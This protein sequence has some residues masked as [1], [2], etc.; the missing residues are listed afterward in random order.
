MEGL[1]GHELNLLDKGLVSYLYISV[2]CQCFRH[3]LWVKCIRWNGSKLQRPI[4]KQF[5]MTRAHLSQSAPLIT[6][7]LAPG[8]FGLKERTAF[9]SI[10][11]PTGSCMVR[12]EVL[13]LLPALRSRF[14]VPLC[15]IFVYWR[16]GLSAQALKPRNVLSKIPLHGGTPVG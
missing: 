2:I 6:L 15:W 16:L 12:F 10:E 8:C 1:G 13:R 3:C 9:D 11:P 14:S 4:D 7:Q 5:S